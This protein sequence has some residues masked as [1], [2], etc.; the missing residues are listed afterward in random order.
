[1]STGD[2]AHAIEHALEHVGHLL[3][4][5]GPIEVFVHHN[6]LHAL[7]DRAGGTG[8]PTRSSASRPASGSVS[9]S[10]LRSRERFALVV[11]FLVLVGG[12]LAPAAAVDVAGHASHALSGPRA[13]GE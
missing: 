8:A 4:A 9:R 7:D 5:Q 11:A 6:T 10:L 13:H 2:L 12:G 1:M 3:P